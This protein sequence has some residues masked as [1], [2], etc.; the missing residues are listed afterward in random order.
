MFYVNA[1]ETPANSRQ[2]SHSSLSKTKK[3]RLKPAK[4]GMV[5]LMSS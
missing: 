4:H 2:F 3:E 5:V 1:K